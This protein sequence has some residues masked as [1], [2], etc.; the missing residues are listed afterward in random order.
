MT[1]KVD[2]DNQLCLAPAVT[3]D[4]SGR[5]PRVR[6]T[7]QIVLLRRSRRRIS[8]RLSAIARRTTLARRR[9]THGD[10]R[11][12]VTGDG[13]TRVDRRRTANHLRGWCPGRALLRE[14]TL[15]ADWWRRTGR[16]VRRIAGRSNTRTAVI[17]C[18]ETLLGI[19]GMNRRRGIGTRSRS[20]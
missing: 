19:G 6:S 14:G 12:R 16:I 20:D 18:L 3:L 5:I 17:H 8:R 1:Y 11:R 15:T 4:L 9:A 2:A 7:R 13:R 10:L